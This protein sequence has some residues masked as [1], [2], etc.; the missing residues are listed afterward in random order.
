[1]IKNGNFAPSNMILCAI[2]LTQINYEWISF[3]IQYNDEVDGQMFKTIDAWLL[4][5]LANRILSRLPHTIWPFFLRSC[6]R[7]RPLCHCLFRLFSSI[8]PNLSSSANIKTLWTKQNNTFAPFI[9]V[10]TTKIKSQNS[11]IVEVHFSIYLYMCVYTLY[12]SG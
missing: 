1:M 3:C 7:V 10:P 2:L 4:I 11:E 9:L 12:S 5:P 8:C 6:L